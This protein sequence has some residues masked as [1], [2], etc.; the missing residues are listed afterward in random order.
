[1]RRTR[2]CPDEARVSSFVGQDVA[3]VAESVNRLKM[4]V[5][6]MVSQPVMA[7]HGIMRVGKNG[8][9]KGCEVKYRPV[10]IGHTRTVLS[11]PMR[12]M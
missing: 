4:A 1:M 8:R 3:R 7:D 11:K 10:S 9:V 12:L 2:N 6:G 5:R